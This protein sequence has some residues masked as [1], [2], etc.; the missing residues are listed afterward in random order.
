MAWEVDVH[1]VAHVISHETNDGR[2]GL[3]STRQGPRFPV[4]LFESLTRRRERC[5]KRNRMTQATSQSRLS[6]P[7]FMTSLLNSPASNAWSGEGSRCGSMTL[8]NE[9]ESRL[10]KRIDTTS[11]PGFRRV[12]WPRILTPHLSICRKR[13]SFPL[14]PNKQTPGYVLVG[15]FP[16]LPPGAPSTTH[17]LRSLPNPLIP[18]SLLPSLPLLPERWHPLPPSP[19][20][21]SVPAL[22]Q[23]ESLL[24]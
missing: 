4:Y 15:R 19:H 9:S 3:A 16:W 2:S 1:P 12:P 7:V 11:K 17:L 8:P 6:C 10:H 23:S 14:R 22:R 13:S 5:W 21:I 20:E 18:S 24:R